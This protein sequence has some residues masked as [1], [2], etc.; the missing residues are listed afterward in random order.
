MA[1]GVGIGYFERVVM[2]LV[3]S[4]GDGVGVMGHRTLRAMAK[5]RNWDMGGEE[6]RRGR[7]ERRAW[8]EMK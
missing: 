7:A 4:T 3:M 5:V 1:K 6:M 2:V 8:Q